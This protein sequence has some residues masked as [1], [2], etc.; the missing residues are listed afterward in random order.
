MNPDCGLKTRRWEEVRPSLRAWWRR[1]SESA[2][3]RSDEITHRE[4]GCP[5]GTRQPFFIFPE[6]SVAFTS[7][8]PASASPVSDEWW[9]KRDGQSKCRWIDL[10]RSTSRDKSP[11]HACHQ[12]VSRRGGRAD[13]TL[14]A[15]RKARASP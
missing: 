1:P 2:P 9:R 5:I 6:S 4:W 7:A 12:R 11:V 10:P 13:Q 3:D 15:E 14:P 8:I